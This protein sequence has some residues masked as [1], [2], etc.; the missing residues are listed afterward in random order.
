MSKIVNEKYN[1]FLR[2]ASSIPKD[3][4][5]IR[6]LYQILS[7]KGFELVDSNKFKLETSSCNLIIKKI[8]SWYCLDGNT[9]HGDNICLSFFCYSSVD[10]E[11]II[12]T[13]IS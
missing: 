13:L 2:I 7:P 1:E 4:L 10:F 6:T 9:R 5:S 11:R 3:E 8:D 12:I